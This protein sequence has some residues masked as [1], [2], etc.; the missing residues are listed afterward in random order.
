MVPSRGR[1]MISFDL[2]GDQGWP[3]L[4]APV[5]ARPGKTLP[6]RRAS[7]IL[8]CGAGW[9]SNDHPDELTAIMTGWSWAGSRSPAEDS[10]ILFTELLNDYLDEWKKVVE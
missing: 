8:R 3:T 7:Y 4:R 10:T 5:V 6:T 9:L 1:A 2:R